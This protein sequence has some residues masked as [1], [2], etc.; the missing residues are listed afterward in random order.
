M[1]GSSFSKRGLGVQ[2]SVNTDREY[3]LKSLTKMTSNQ[4][5][6]LR[7]FSSILIPLLAFILQWVLWPNLP[8]LTWMLFYPAVLSSAWLGVGVGGFSALLLAAILGVFYF[9]SS[10]FSWDI[11][12]HSHIFSTA[13]LITSGLMFSLIFEHL[14]RSGNK[15]RRIKDLELDV[16]Q[17][18][19]AQAL[20][21]A[22]AGAW[23][24]N[25]ATDETEWSDS[26]WQLYGLTPGCCRP[27]Y[28]DWLKSVHPEDLIKV[29]TTVNYALGLKAEFVVVWRVAN[30]QNGEQ[31]WLMARGL[32]E[33]SKNGDL[34]CYQGIT[35]DITD[36]KIIE[37]ALQEK[38][39]LLADSQAIAHIGSWVRYCK[40]GKVIWSE[41]TYR[42]MGLSPKTDQP[43]NMEQ[44]LNL[45][46]PDDRLAAQIWHD[47]CFAG[48][49]P[50]PLE[51]RTSPEFGQ[52]R[53]LL[54]YG[55]REMD[56]NGMPERI[57]GTV[58]DITERKQAEE[59][60]RKL[61]KAVEQSPESIVITDV[62][63]NIEYVNDA[64]TQ[65]SGYL[66]EE[67]L[68]KKTSILKSNQTPDKT[69]KELWDT[70][71]HGETWKGEFINK[72]K[73]GSEYVNF[74]KISPIRQPD[75][76]ITHFVALQEDITNKKQIDKELDQHR[77]HLEELVASR[78]K[79]LCATQLLAENANKAK[80]VFLANM[81]HEI[82]TPMNAIIG[83][84]YLLQE[85]TL[86]HEQKRHLQQIDSS[87]QHLLAI[88]NDILD[89]SKIE[90]GQMKLDHT[91]F[92]LEAIF[93]QINSMLSNQAKNK[94]ITIEFNHDGVPL[95]LCG[96][97]TRLRQALI[98]YAANALKF[99][100]HGG[101]YISAKLLEESDTEL[102][103]LFE[104]KDTGI[105]ISKETLP[106]LFEAFNQAD[107]ST[108]R[109]YG[110]T[111][112]GLAITRKLANAMGGEAG[113]KSTL[114]KGS[115]FW[116]S[117]KIQKGHAVENSTRR[118]ESTNSGEILR[119]SHAGARLL[120][121]EDNPINREISL[122]LLHAVGLFVDTAENGRVALNKVE[123]NTYD[124]VLM[125]VQMPVMDGLSATKAIRALP[126]NKQLPILAMTANAFSEDIQICLDAGMNDFIVKPT[127]PEILYNKLLNWL[128]HKELSR[129]S[130]ENE[131]QPKCYVRV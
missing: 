81:S 97:P 5:S 83:L 56:A 37:Q 88:I 59:Q 86:S 35:M 25:P 20:H 122:A 11:A 108:T 33:S 44:F 85:S 116:F 27:S 45:V 115:V 73:D 107:I 82:R 75:G 8:P 126:G 15:L 94:G 89:L 105:G 124:L 80:S 52:V 9:I 111:G 113:V 67:I 7:V 57:I 63:G 123:N 49:S 62:S 41:E 127:P 18:R 103:V 32:P 2:A 65:N 74:A 10:Q 90:A 30:V 51:Y 38:E 93:D 17:K 24:W 87:A 60:L 46:H 31:R 109:E 120:L 26:I 84:S 128:S 131:T 68:G 102:F 71:S 28:E 77:H 40:T 55:I 47:E 22:N 16:Q 19:L 78:T 14:H 61:T 69:Y 34:V 43:P 72:R 66:P 54:R 110:G 106:I 70:I 96:D 130:K 79:E 12:D 125:D 1:N 23:K 6:A 119:R 117:V 29:V 36:R 99:T 3:I 95:W 121:A 76:K 64:Y 53:W 114:G 48:N 21:A 91:D 50:Q 100:E 42:L 118:L 104:V 4:I 112:L 13:I 39:R 58:Q 101:I 129:D 98:N 92:N